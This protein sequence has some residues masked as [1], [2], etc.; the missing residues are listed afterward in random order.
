MTDILEALSPLGALGFTE[1]SISAGYGVA[2]TVDTWCPITSDSLKYDQPQK[3]QET[4][5]NNV[6][7]Q[8][9]ADG[10]VTAGG[11]IVLPVFGQT[12][13]GWLLKWL[14]RS[15]ASNAF[16]YAITAAP[17]LNATGSGSNTGAFF[18]A[19][20]TVVKETASGLLFLTQCSPTSLVVNP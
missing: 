11:N 12:A 3:E 6:D 14:P 10:L 15:H 19:V 7:I 18:Y 9:S 1:E 16:P 20:A 17:T 5:F 13:F 8:D 4:I 2:Q